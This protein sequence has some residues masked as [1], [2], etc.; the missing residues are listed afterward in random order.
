MD[1]RASD[2]ERDATF[3]QLREAAAEGRLTLEELTD[4][5]EAA[6]NGT[7]ATRARRRRGFR[8]AVDFRL[9][10]ST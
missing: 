6:S 1:V 4:R 8:V 2:A 3:E 9:A 10:R 7:P 5:I